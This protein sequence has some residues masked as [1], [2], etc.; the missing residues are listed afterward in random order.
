MTLTSI[1]VVL[2]VTGALIA[3]R[4]LV[5]LLFGISRMDPLTYVG[6]VVVISCVSA[7]AYLVPAW[8]A[9]QVDPSTTLR[10]E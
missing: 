1:G 4:A 5:S 2:G 3:S 9:A 6:V 7:I 8:R 10:A